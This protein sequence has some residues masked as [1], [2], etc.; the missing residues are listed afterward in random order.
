[1]PQ[2]AA[3]LRAEVSRRLAAEQ[4]SAQQ[5]CNL[6]WA[7]ALLRVRP[8][9]VEVLGFGGFISG[10]QQCSQCSQPCCGRSGCSG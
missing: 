8:S 5:L 9:R 3:A 6:L 2:L 1:M 10:K 4:L 7:L